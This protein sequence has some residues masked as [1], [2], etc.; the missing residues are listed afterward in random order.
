MYTYTHV[1]KH[2][3]TCVISYHVMLAYH[4]ASTCT[5][6][7]LPTDNNAPRREGG[8]ARWTQYYDI[9]IT[10]IDCNVI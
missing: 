8:G 2:I 4:M 6:G 5:K 7:R 9:V 3:Y 10:I 1:H